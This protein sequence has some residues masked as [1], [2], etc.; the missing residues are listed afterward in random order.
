[1]QKENKTI[2][3]KHILLDRDGVLNRE[4]PSGY[5]LSYDQWE[6]IPGVLNALSKISKLGIQLSIVTN[7]SCIN[8]GLITIDEIEKI[9]SEIRLETKCFSINFNG[10]YICPHRDEDKCDCRKPKTGLLEKAISNSK[11]PK[12]DTII[13]GDSITDIQAG[14]NIGIDSWLVRTG[15]G[16]N[17]E[18]MLDKYSVNKSKII[19]FNDL[20]EVY[21]TILKNGN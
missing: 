16:T 17:S 5:V 11:I 20:N 8:K 2:I 21:Q 9:H 13:I 4:H 18:Y 1:M 12:K 15:K 10:I 19:I 14:Q 7:Q 3:N 6:W